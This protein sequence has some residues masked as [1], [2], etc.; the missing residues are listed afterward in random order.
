[1]IIANF[2][3][4]LTA[5]LITAYY[6]YRY[7]EQWYEI[8]SR[9]GVS[10]I[11][12]YSAKTAYF[13]L[14]VYVYLLFHWMGLRLA[15]LLNTGA[16]PLNPLVLLVDKIPYIVSFNVIYFILRKRYGSTAGFLWLINVSAYSTLAGFQVD[17][18][19]AL[20]ILAS[21][22]YM[23]EA[24]VDRSL[25][26]AS[27][28]TSVKQ[29]F[30]F[31]GLIPF[32]VLWRKNGFKVALKKL[33][34]YFVLP[35]LALSLPFLLRDPVDFVYKSLFFHGYRY[36]QDLSL[37][38]IPMYIIVF[39][40]QA[41]P[42]FITWGWVI[43]FIIFMAL[44]TVKLARDPL[45]ERNILYYYVI[46]V[47]GMIVLNKVGGLNYLTWLTPLLIAFSSRASG[48]LSMKLKCIS[49][50]LP[51]LS[52]VLYPFFTFFAATIVGGD[53][54]IVEDSSWEP[55][56]GI[57]YASYGYYNPLVGLI[58]V[59]KSNPTSYF[60]FKSLYNAIPATSIAVTLIYN[61]TIIY[62]ISIAWRLT[63]Y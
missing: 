1:V 50:A 31:T 30:V 34:I 10:E 6:D 55:A 2:F 28:A 38:A 27:L 12:L 24:R 57:F 4:A 47:A 17:L 60:I 44:L 29:I 39:N 11:Y 25:L 36:P 48:N 42:G 22:V 54:Y 40:V 14:T 51:L 59:L 53:I 13:P 45:V 62:A 43:P 46:M 21:M 15:S 56:E 49:I 18:L 23:E 61:L 8:A 5:P 63:R 16:S 19:V 52:L 3:I 35:I 26:L 37:W 32:V 7:F 58:S 41:L 20:L 33:L 9:F